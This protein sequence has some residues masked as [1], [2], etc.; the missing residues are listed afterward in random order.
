M[1]LSTLDT[2]TK[3]IYHEI[4]EENKY[5]TLQVMDYDTITTGKATKVNNNQTPITDMSLIDEDTFL[6]AYYHTKLNNIVVKIIKIVGTKIKSGP[7]CVVDE[8]LN[9]TVISIISMSKDRVILTYNDNLNRVGKVLHLKIINNQ[10]EIIEKYFFADGFVP[11]LVTFKLTEH[12]YVMFYQ[13]EE[14]GIM[15]VTDIEDDQ[16]IMQPEKT[17]Y[18]DSDLWGLAIEKIHNYFVIIFINSNNKLVLKILTADERLTF[19]SATVF[20]TPVIDHTF[21]LMSVAN[22][23][24]MCYFNNQVQ[25]LSIIN[26]QIMQPENF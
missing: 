17:F 15:R 12:Q 1:I 8:K 18:K 6:Y 19:T 13:F 14:Y 10:V 16:L 24:A 20:T 22:E 26:G 25:I 4:E 2:E 5:N 11:E 21:E 7:V 23:F 3:T 9:T